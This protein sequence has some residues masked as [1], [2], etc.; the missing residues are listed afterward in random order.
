MIRHASIAMIC[1]FGLGNALAQSTAPPAADFQATLWASSCMA[2]H[3]T[4]GLAEA[5]GLTIGNRPADKLF[6]ML[7]AFKSGQ[8]QSTVMQQ[9]VLGYSDE[10]LQRIAQY[11][12]RIK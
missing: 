6:E 9:H 1:T 8:R 12:S 5:T 7:R 3:G 4:D 2:C 10:E 11:F